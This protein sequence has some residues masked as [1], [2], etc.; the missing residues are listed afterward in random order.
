MS[1]KPLIAILMATYNPQ[2]DWFQKQLNSLNNQTYE[3]LVLYIQDD[4]SEYS[5]YKK[6]EEMVAHSITKFQYEIDRNEVNK[7][8]N[9]TFEALTRK[10]NA[11]I[12]AYCDQDD[13]WL[14]NKLE[15]LEDI[16]SKNP[17]AAMVYGTVIK[18]DG[19]DNIIKYKSA[20]TENDGKISSPD[21]YQV[22]MRGA[23]VFGCALIVKSDVAKSAV[24][25]SPYC[26]HDR[27]LTL[28]ALSMGDVIKVNTPVIKYRRSGGNQSG[29]LKG[30]EDKKTYYALMKKNFEYVDSLIDSGI[31]S[32]KLL[33]EIHNCQ[34]WCMA[35]K[36]FW[37]S[38][39]LKYLKEMFKLKYVEK[40]YTFFEPIVRIM[41]NFL[42]KFSLKFYRKHISR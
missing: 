35:R 1:T 21:H 28:I 7:G 30:V 37:N 42:F 2:L 4:C 15:Y 16:L 3:N 31:F 6:I 10:A 40:S 39:K 33:E 41:P 24:P 19:Q 36:N 14:P 32:G 26:F 22:I 8:S 20:M 12:F 5:I 25:F 34:R 29:F 17:N 18:I 27:Y 11:P 9:K 38:L 13:I 23:L